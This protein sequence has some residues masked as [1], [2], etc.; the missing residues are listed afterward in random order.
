MK[1]LAYTI[2]AAGSL[3]VCVCLLSLAQRLV[4]PF[5]LTWFGYPS[6]YWVELNPTGL[7]FTSALA[8]LLVLLGIVLADRSGNE[9]S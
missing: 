9:N 1:A 5:S 8:L 4:G 2:L 3:L 6:G 7:T